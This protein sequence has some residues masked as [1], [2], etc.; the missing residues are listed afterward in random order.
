MA[1][2]QNTNPEVNEEKKVDYDAIFGK[3]DAIL[4]KRTDGLAKSA[5]KDNMKDNGIEE[6]EIADIVK[7]YRQQKQTKADEQKQNLDNAQKTI[8]ELQKQIAD[9]DINDALTSEILDSGIDAKTLPYALKLCNRDVLGEDGKPNSE[10]VKA[11]IAKVLSDFPML[12][13]ASQGGKGFVPVGAD[14]TDSDKDKDE[15]ESKLRKYFGLK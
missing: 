10:K 2:E 9:R 4:D 13:L 11:E 8:A 3:L 7:A 6:S 14:E 12:K 5:L 1:E 15:A